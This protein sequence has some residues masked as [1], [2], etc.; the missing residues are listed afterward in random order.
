MQKDKSVKIYVAGHRG[1]AG[2]ACTELLRKEGYLNILTR[3]H[4]ELDLTCQ[5]AVFDFLKER[6]QTGSSFARQES[7]ELQ[8]KPNS[9]PNSSMTIS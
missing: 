7:V 6:S 3:T 4:K 8:T 9:R 2:K 5:S 1:V